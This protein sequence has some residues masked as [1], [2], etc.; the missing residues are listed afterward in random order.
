MSVMHGAHLECQQDA[1]FVTLVCGIIAGWDERNED[2]TKPD[3]PLCWSVATHC[4]V[5]GTRLS[6]G[7]L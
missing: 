7:W 3:C 4:P 1:P 6:R 5:C 2:S